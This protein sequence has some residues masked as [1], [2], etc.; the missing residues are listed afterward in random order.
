MDIEALAAALDIPLRPE[1]LPAI[2]AN[3]ELSLRFAQDVA[4]FPLDDEA[5]A[6]PV[7]TP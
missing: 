4:A 3:L 5:G 6:A 7:F 1:W 2:R